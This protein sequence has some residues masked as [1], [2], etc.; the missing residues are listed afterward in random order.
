MNIL[1]K[2]FLLDFSKEQNNR[3]TKNFISQI[4]L[5]SSLT[6]FQIFFPPL[7]IMIYGLESFGVWVFLT[8]IPSMLSIL[9]FDLNAAAKT[10]MSIYFNQN[11]NKKVN[12]VFNNAIILTV[13][14]VVILAIIGFLIVI[15]YDFN[16]N[17]LKNLD[18]DE[19][20]FILICVF[21]T[22][23]L[24]IFNSIFKTGITF[25]G[26]LDLGTYLEIYFDLFTKLFIIIMGI[27][28]NKLLFAFIAL[29]GANILK[30]IIFY[31]F[32]L[33]YNKCLTLFS[34]K[35]VSKKKIFRLIKLSIPYYFES[36]SNI[37]KH[38]FQIIILGIFFNAQIVGMVSTLKTLFYFL[39][40]RAWG[41]FS[42]VLFYEFT[43]LYTE[44]K[45][46]KLKYIYFNFLKLGTI[47]LIIFLSTS[48]LFG[49]YIYTLWLNNSYSLDYYLLI[50]IIMDVIFV[51]S[52]GSITYVNKSINKFFKISLFQLNIHV[53]VIV[54]SYLFFINQQTYYLLFLLNLIGS[55]LILIYSIYFSKNLKI[56]NNSKK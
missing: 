29:L 30:V 18:S 53:I 39:P 48:L 5:N 27:I 11:N 38:S 8:A 36:V 26:R 37:F 32:Y 19:L 7:M 40:I 3:V 44:K 49:E 23:Y 42:K 14:F 9:N 1:K 43:K 17:I 4:S 15:S 20:K 54:A 10:E 21:L 28:F 31:F 55:F 46:D 41:V 50:L 56:F 13:I 12:E 25:W 45:F 16:L 2:I 34:F 35:L 51:L 47:F 24:N 22:F 52:A 6:F 33:K